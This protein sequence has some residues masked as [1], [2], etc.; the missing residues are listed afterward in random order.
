MYGSV[1]GNLL[2]LLFFLLFEACGGLWAFALL[3]GESRSV[4]LLF[5]SVFGTVSLQWFPVLFSFIFG[6]TFLSHLLGL[7]LALLLGLMAGLFLWRH[8]APPA[9]PAQREKPVFL[10]R[11]FFWAVF[12]LWLVFCVLVWRS[13][14]FQEGKIYSSQ[15]TYGD[16]SMHLSFITSLSR[17]GDFPPD[18][19][20]LPG[21]RLSYPFLSD[22]ISSSLYLFGASLKLSYTFPMWV[23]GAQI[24]FGGW[25]FLLRL[26]QGREGKAALAWCFFFLNGGLGVF[27]FLGEGKEGFLRIFRELYQTPTNFTEK[28]IRWVNVIVDMMLPQRA[29]LFGWAVLFPLLYLLCRAVFEKKRRYFLVCGVLGGL[30][31]MIH[32]HSFL[33]FALVCGVW[34]LFSLLSS[35]DKAEQIGRWAAA[36]GLVLLW[37][38]KHLLDFFHW[39]NGAFL[40]VLALLFL[41]A[42]A[43]GLFFLLWK[44]RR[45][46]EKVFSSWGLLFFSACLFAVPQLFYWTL[47]QAGPGGFVRGHFGWA[48]GEEDYLWFYLKNIGPAAVLAFLGLISAKQGNFMRWA[49]G[50]VIWLIAELV[51][52]QPNEYDNNKL[53]YPAFL[54][55]CCAA[56]DYAFFLF[57]KLKKGISRRAAAVLTALLCSVSAWLTLGREFVSRYELYG[58]GALTLCS[59]IE[60][61]LSP[62]ALV[63]TDTRHNNEVASLT[64]RNVLCGSPSY[65][66]F[67]GLDYWENEEAARAIYET[68]KAS[69]GLFSR[70]RV[71][72]ILVSD[73]ERDAYEVDEKALGELFPLIYHD[74]N[75]KLYQVTEKDRID[76]AV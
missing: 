54:F 45:R 28:G 74:G 30:L 51:V 2:G 14:L 33:S 72:Y 1:P 21:A 67:H 69:F 11:R 43:G 46:G 52:F 48:M 47:H 12:A 42:G 9:A 36:V 16:M 32:T 65:L 53:L 17:Q 71:E 56:S 18:Y 76:K 44:S 31:P 62:D 29:T 27:Y 35:T 68:P 59:Y 39:R 3:P 15:A 26:L 7:S 6:F 13:F 4:K 57:E 37:L 58:T 40:L 8:K 55:F 61:N 34:M 10:R 38:G 73:F 63:L 49:P 25:L 41:T 60:K 66:F 50:P 22:S 19:S 64:G 23:A 20:I 24:L 75:R 70:F 5:G